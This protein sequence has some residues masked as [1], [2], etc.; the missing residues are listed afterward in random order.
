MQFQ[1]ALNANASQLNYSLLNLYSIAVAIGYQAGYSNQGKESVAI[2]YQAG[3]SNQNQS[4]VAIG[5]QAG[6]SNQGTNSIAIGYQAG[7]SNQH[8]NS[9]IINA[10]DL[11]LNSDA[12]GAFY[13]K[14]IA[15]T[16]SALSNLVYDTNTGEILY[17]TAKTFVIPHPLKND[18]YLVHACLEGPE[19]GVY[20][21]GTGKIKENEN[22]PNKPKDPVL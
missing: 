15:S 2:G 9:I 3:Y 1:L 10:S 22:T 4:A 18:K 16:S 14:P 21:R 6:Y 19:A 17:Q 7:Y 12:S 8:E 5:Y 13:I 20:Y 11:S